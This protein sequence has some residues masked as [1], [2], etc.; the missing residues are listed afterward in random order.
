MCIADICS[1][2]KKIFKYLINVKCV[3]KITNFELSDACIEALELS[4]FCDLV[5]RVTTKGLQTLSRVMEF[6]KFLSWKPW[7]SQGILFCEFIGHPV[8]AEI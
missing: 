2:I 3:V 8:E 7:K 5:V 6:F 4:R 1:T